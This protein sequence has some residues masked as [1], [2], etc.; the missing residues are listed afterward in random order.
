MPNGKFIDP[1]LRAVFMKEIAN[2]QKIIRRS[3]GLSYYVCGRK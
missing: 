2:I 3:Y 1:I